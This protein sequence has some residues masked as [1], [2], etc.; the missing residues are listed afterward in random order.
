MNV[1]RWLI[2]Y[3]DVR[4]KVLSR[5]DETGAILQ[6]ELPELWVGA[7]DKGS[8]LPSS[9]YWVSSD[10]FEYLFDCAYEIDHP[11]EMQKA[12]FQCP[13]LIVTCGVSQRSNEARD[14]YRIR[15]FP[16]GAASTLDADSA[17]RFDRGHFMA[18][19]SG[20]GLGINLFPQLTEVNRGRSDKGKV[21]REMERR[22][23]RSPGTYFFSRPIYSGCTDHPF[24]IEFGMQ[25]AEQGLWVELF[26]NCLTSEEMVGIEEKV[27]AKRR[28]SD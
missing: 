2:D 7:Y 14:A 10:G 21:Y 27:A 25:D 3:S 26:P 1:D 15:K 6:S 20:G 12:E 13:R 5:P 8:P 28:G 23:A 11:P 16:R 9:A 22:L 17:N 4:E 18:H 24:Q 19:A